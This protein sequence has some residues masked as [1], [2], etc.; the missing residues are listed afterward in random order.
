M[1][2]R[3]SSV[4]REEK[5]GADSRGIAQTVYTDNAGNSSSRHPKT[6]GGL[7][8]RNT[9]HSC[10]PCS[11][12]NLNPLMTPLHVLLQAEAQYGLDSGRRGARSAG[13]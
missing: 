11:H 9:Q 2:K 10:S 8:V 3:F 7:Q 5:I 4:V 13:L 1:L 6:P 12:S